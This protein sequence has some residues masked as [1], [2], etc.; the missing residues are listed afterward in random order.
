MAFAWLTA[1][2]VTFL[3]NRQHFGNGL[4]QQILLILSISHT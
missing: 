2:R 4:P 1:W 3:F